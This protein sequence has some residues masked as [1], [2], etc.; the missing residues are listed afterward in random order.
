METGRFLSVAA[1]SSPGTRPDGERVVLKVKETA[2]AQPLS[3]PPEEITTV[4][5]HTREWLTRPEKWEEDLVVE[6]NLSSADGSHLASRLC[7]KPLTGV[8]LELH[9][10]PTG[11]MKRAFEGI[12]VTHGADLAWLSP[13]AQRRSVGRLPGYGV[14]TLSLAP[15]Q[16][17]QEGRMDFSFGA[18]LSSRDTG[19]PALDFNIAPSAVF[20]AAQRGDWVKSEDGKTF[21]EDKNGAHVE[22]DAST[23]KLQS[24][25]LTDPS[26]LG[27]FIKLT[28]A[29]GA[30]AAT[31]A[32]ADQTAKS[33]PTGPMPILA[34]VGD[35]LNAFGPPET[36]YGPMLTM[37]KGM[38][39]LSTRLQGRLEL[40][41]ADEPK[42]PHEFNVCILP[43]QA[44]VL[45]GAPPG[46]EFSQTQAIAC[47]SLTFARLFPRESCP[48]TIL[49]E[50]GYLLLG[51]PQHLG[52]EVQRALNDPRTGPLGYLEMAERSGSLD[53]RVLRR[54]RKGALVGA[55]GSPSI[56]RC[57]SSPPEIPH[58]RN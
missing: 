27:G 42:E 30:Y 12:L 48:W 41:F 6:V 54:S 39:S 37:L 15:D 16:V 58:S 36:D 8:V 49:N 51:K 29:R 46:T 21:I 28:F 45:A 38:A 19:T 52:E 11:P 10:A 20:N 9:F 55:P 26:S 25:T 35:A 3:R 14:F 32:R 43:E 44:P 7:W 31:A 5:Q 57:A 18:G 2:W 33:W 34:I 13:A 47:W 56:G 40:L 50:T 17:S 24:V 22:I 1:D 4:L 53:R 23:G